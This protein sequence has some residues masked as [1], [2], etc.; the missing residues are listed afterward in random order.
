[1]TPSGGHQTIVSRVDSITCLTA[2]PLGDTGPP[3]KYHKHKT[4]D[5]DT[6]SDFSSEAEEYEEAMAHQ[7]KETIHLGTIHG[8]HDLRAMTVP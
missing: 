3:F 7:L 2:P 4:E 5:S 6:G 8:P 1:V